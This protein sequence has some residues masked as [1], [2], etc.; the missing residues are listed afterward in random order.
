MAFVFR[1][2]D[3][4]GPY[5]V[6]RPLGEGGMGE[7]HLVRGP[8][9]EQRA[10]KV[11]SA[12]AQQ[13]RELTKRFLGEIQVLSYLEHA[14]VVRFYDTGTFERDGQTVLWLA[15]EFLEGRT[16]REILQRSRG[17]LD[18]DALI[19]WGRQIAQGVH[20]AHKLK[21]IHRDLKPENVIV[22]GEG[23]AKV[24]DFGIA[25][26]RDW[27]DT[28][29]RTSGAKIGTVL[30][31]APEQLDDALGVPIDERT[32]VYGLGVILYELATG[33]NPY[34]DP[35]GSVDMA[36]L[37]LRKLTSTLPPVRTLVPA[38]S[39]DLAAVIDRACDHDARNR[40]QGMD[41]LFEAL[42]AVWRRRMD[43]RRERMLGGSRGSEPG[44][45]PGPPLAQPPSP[46][47]ATAKTAWHAPPEGQSSRFESVRT[48][49]EVEVP[50][51]AR[52]LLRD[53]ALLGAALGIASGLVLYRAQVAP[54]LAASAATRAS[55]A[56]KPATATSEAAVERSRLAAGRPS[57]SSAAA[58]S[59][60][61]TPSGEARGASPAEVTSAASATPTAPAA[62]T[63]KPD[64]R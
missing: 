4:C 51:Q 55:E 14:H 26:F 59:V 46:P 5:T 32:D 52:T 27:G 50:T 34:V 29:S 44:P 28:R 37:L 48:L 2:G 64:A 9:G 56:S 10:L 31:M 49:P 57:T 38:L 41:A 35:G 1:P 47:Q 39:S 8:S 20:E 12:T 17:T 11:L 25:K 45:T 63:S 60:A 6:V 42:G 23:M 62:T 3:S 7:V 54:R 19:R 21:V 43:E 61:A 53:A 33:R 58:G 16:L 40:F 24:I 30:Y 22:V 18:E 36:N 13:S 15:L